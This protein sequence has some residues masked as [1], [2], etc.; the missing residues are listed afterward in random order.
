MTRTTRQIVLLLVAAVSFLLA[1]IFVATPSLVRD[2]Q[3]PE[4]MRGMIAWLAKHPADWLTASAIADRSLD[5][6]LPRRVEIWRGSYRQALQLAPRRPNTSAGF[7]RAGLFHWTELGPHD[8]N[9]ILQAAIP[10]IRDP[11]HFGV[12]YQ[13]LFTLTRNFPWLRRNAPDGG[14]IRAL[15]EL[16]A[17]NGLFAEYRETREAVHRERLRELHARRGKDHPTELVDLLPSPISSADEPLVRTILEDLDRDPFHPNHSSARIEDLARYAIRHHLQPLGGLAGLIETPGILADVTRAR[18]AL[19]MGNVEQAGRVELTVPQTNAAEWVPYFLDRARFE[20]HRGDAALADAY[21]G[22]AALIGMTDDVLVAA[23]EI[24]SILGQTKNVERYRQELAAAAR[25]PRVWKETCGE[26]E[27]C[28]KAIAREY[29]AQ[30]QTIRIGASVVQTDEVAPY[31]EIY[32][33]DALVAEGE[34]RDERAFAMPV[35]AGL[36]RIEV[37]LVNPFTRNRIQRRVRLS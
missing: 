35:G 11:Q 26:N 8:R 31:L 10:L 22:R 20:A 6:D 32:V 12:L 34:V 33:D 30:S 37:R 3:R 5:S 21:L 23:V 18:L 14:A 25:K 2:S 17:T 1:L 24:A 4:T 15:N 7:V 28:T 29:A 9:A 36:H 16:A 27:I 19:A 13:P